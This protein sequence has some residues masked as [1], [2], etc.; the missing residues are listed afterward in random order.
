M[1]WKLFVIFQA[2]FKNLLIYSPDLCHYMWHAH[3]FYTLC[4]CMKTFE[5]YCAITWQHFAKWEAVSFT[6]N[7]TG[8]QF[9]R[10]RTANTKIIQ[11]KIIVAPEAKH[12][13]KAPR[14][15]QAQLP[16][17]NTSAKSDGHFSNQQTPHKVLATCT[18]SRHVLSAALTCYASWTSYLGSPLC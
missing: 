5:K 11:K 13:V 17:S 2:C 10:M 8:W 9:N 7:C 15:P 12:L 1:V 16:C 18:P 6:H 14:L 3:Q 4:Q